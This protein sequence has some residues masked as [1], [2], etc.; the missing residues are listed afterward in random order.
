MPHSAGS[1]G[2]ADFASAFGGGGGGGGGV[3]TP[4]PPPLTRPPG[5]APTALTPPSGGADLLG[6]MARK[7]HRSMGTHIFRHSQIH[8]QE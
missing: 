7:W 3:P 8:R 6:G 5:T 2:F 1:D 4:A